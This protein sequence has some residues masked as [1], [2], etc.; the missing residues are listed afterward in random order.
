MPIVSTFGPFTSGDVITADGI[1]KTFKAIE[2][3]INHGIN[4][5]D[6][7][8]ERWI[9][10]KHLPRPEFFGAPSPRVTLMTADVHYRQNHGGSG[11]QMYTHM[12]SQD[13]WLAI[14]GLSMSIF[15]SNPLRGMGS[16]DNDELDTSTDYQTE[17]YELIPSG[18]E[19]F[20]QV[21]AGVVCCNFFVK[22]Q[23]HKFKSAFKNDAQYF[24]TP[25]Q[26]IAKFALFVNQKE[27]SGTQRLTFAPTSR[28]SPYSYKNHNI[29]APVQLKMGMNHISV[30]IKMDNM[31]DVDYWR[32]LYVK[33]RYMNCEVCYL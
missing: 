4:R 9:E 6:I 7:S 8:Q 29:L 2:D 27:V 15:V 24:D 22:P 1:N 11:S 19:D 17:A 31:A 20:G 25:S 28:N 5:D 33:A 32:N 3:Y 12:L 26:R 18:S 23:Q 21:V 13:R 30:R 16:G 14:P 10:H